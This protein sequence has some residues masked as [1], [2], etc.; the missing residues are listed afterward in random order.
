[1]V[2]SEDKAVTAP[3]IDYHAFSPA[4]GDSTRAACK[5]VGCR[6]GGPKIGEAVFQAFGDLGTQLN[7]CAG[8]AFADRAKRLRF[9][10]KFQR[11]QFF[12]A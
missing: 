3:Q 9:K 6:S 8:F 7:A 11:S 1:M 2:S 12:I 10:R 5:K 4:A